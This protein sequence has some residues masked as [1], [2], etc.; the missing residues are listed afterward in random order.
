MPITIA[1]S[2]LINSATHLRKRMIAIPHNIFQKIEEE[3]IFSNSFFEVSI[4]LM[5]NQ[6]K[7]LKNIRKLQTNIS[8]E[9]RCENPHPNISKSITIK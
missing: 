9:H 4:T 6:G 1:D 7:T 8:H 5:L 3:G 2:S